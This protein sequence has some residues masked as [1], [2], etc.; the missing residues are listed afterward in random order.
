LDGATF[1]YRFLNGGW[2]GCTLECEAEKI[3]RRAR[4]LVPS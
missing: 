2:D 1:D 4:G 3:L